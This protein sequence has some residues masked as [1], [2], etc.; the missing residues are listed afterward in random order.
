[1]QKDN[2]HFLKNGRNSGNKIDSNIRNKNFSEIYSK[3]SSGLISSQSARCLDCGNP[4]CHWQC[5]VHNYI[6]RWLELMREGKLFE[7]ADIASET[8]PLPEVCGRICPQDRLCEG[9]CTLN[10]EFGAVTI[11]SVEKYILD[12]AIKQGWQP[13][14]SQIKN[15]Y[16]VAIIGAGPAGL[17]CAYKLAK[18]GT[19]VDVYDK[20]PQ[21]GGLLT[22]G[23][24]NF[25]LDK[26][27]MSRRKEIFENMG[28]KFLLNTYVTDD[29]FKNIYDEYDAV[30]FATGAYDARKANLNENNIQGIY[31]ALDYLNNATSIAK[32][33]TSMVNRDI[34]HN[35]VGKKVI[36]LGG[37]D[38]AMD[39]SRTA[40]RQGADSV[41][42]IYRRSESSM[43]GSKNE[44]S[45]AKEE[46][47]KFIW[48][49]QVSSIKS[50]ANQIS[51]VIAD[52]YAI[53]NGSLKL[54]KEQARILECDIVLIAYG[55][56]ADSPSW[57]SNYGID[58]DSRQ[59]VVA[60]EFQKYPGQ[61]TNAKVFSGGDMVRGANLVVR[62][63][64]DG[65]QSADAIIRYL[66]NDL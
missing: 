29:M 34:P 63:V 61:T 16:K 35:L 19:S 21:I 30:Y 48:N 3:P 38:T 51:S 66:E 36:V 50:N 17:S 64:F 54:V 46:G 32:N 62:A 10:D 43:P 5:P 37:G 8:N 14:I 45:L 25:K 42:C 22:F 13:K 39:C 28:I 44:V 18:V 1:M 27:V 40:I 56:E 58:I 2:L 53:D 52:Q 11:G 59:R 7:A 31:Y 65:R 15:G 4:Y 23:I 6:P 26:D 57:L 9:A 12:E 24:P 60:S 41:T 55:F 49:H 20:Y 47:V 33:F